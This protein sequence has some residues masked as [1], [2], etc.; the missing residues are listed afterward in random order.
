MK[1][2]RVFLIALVLSLVVFAQP[3]YASDGL[4]SDGWTWNESSED[5]APTTDTA[6]VPAPDAP[7]PDPD[8]PAPDAPAPD[9]DVLEPD[10][11]APDPDAPAPDAL[12]PDGWT[13]DEAL[14]PDGWTW[15]ETA[16]PSPG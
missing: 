1:R 15:D 10:A 3:A 12:A 13:W 14:N 16:L 7:A 5:V 4:V 2:S 6:D 11:P 9:P 8:A